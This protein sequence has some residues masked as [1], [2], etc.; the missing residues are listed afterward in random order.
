MRK[1]LS[2][3][4]ALLVF[5]PI[6]VASAWAPE[7]FFDTPD[8]LPDDIRANLPQDAVFTTAMYN[9]DTVFVAVE[10]APDISRL[11][12]YRLTDGRYQ[13]LTKSADLSPVNGFPVS[14]GSSRRNTVYLTAGNSIYT[15]GETANEDWR[16]VYVQDSENY[17]VM[18]NGIRVD[19]DTSSPC[20]Y[21]D[22][23]LWQL[24]SLDSN[25]L[26][27][28]LDKAIATVNSDRWAVVNN[29]N[30]KDRLNLRIK[31]NPNARS[32]GKYYNGTPVKVL[33][34]LDGWAQVDVCGVQGYMMAA[35]LVSGKHLSTNQEAFPH[36]MLRD[37]VADAPLPI[38]VSPS[39]SAEI[40]GSMHRDQ[41][42]WASYVIVG[43][44]GN[45]WYHIM[46]T[47]GLCGYVPSEWFW[48][49][50]G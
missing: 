2:M 15:F 21:G 38:H 18:F 4:L 49:G 30:P 33:R 9:G 29:D 26:P 42:A 27:Q 32:L 48:P 46:Y 1:A 31:P 19:N 11:L 22:V 40:V 35:Y 37:S 25:T 34:E 43:I 39:E 13:L 17:A 50:N 3:L 10:P 47:D 24:S 20:Y 23:P 44:V 7:G 14:F 8:D 5:I 36:M 41:Y 12:I 45:D 16:L 28:D 6:A